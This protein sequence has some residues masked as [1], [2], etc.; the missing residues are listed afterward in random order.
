MGD[1]PVDMLNAIWLNQYGGTERCKEYLKAADPVRDIWRGSTRMPVA[2]KHRICPL[3]EAT[4][5]LAFD[6]AGRDVQ[7]IR[8][9]RE[10]PFS[11]RFICPKGVALRDLDADPDRLRTPMIRGEAG[12]RAATWKEAFELIDN[13][14][15]EIISRHG[16]NAVQGHLWRAVVIPPTTLIQGHP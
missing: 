14:L 11:R 12:W 3:C 8:G 5:G 7:S 1:P 4:C 10:D 9:D 13:R 6:V 15:S 2:E 16:K